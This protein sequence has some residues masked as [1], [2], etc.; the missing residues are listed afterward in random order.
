MKPLRQPFDIVL[1]TIGISI[2]PGMIIFPI[3]A[4]NEPNFPP[5]INKKQDI[6]RV[7]FFLQKYFVLLVRDC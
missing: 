5:E 3:A 4:G 6:Y 2:D 1:N 7:T